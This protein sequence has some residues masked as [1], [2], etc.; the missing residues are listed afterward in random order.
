MGASGKLETW[1]RSGD[2]AKIA[3]PTLVIGAQHDTMDPKHMAWMAEQLPRG[4]F[5]LCPNGGHAALYDDQEA[6]FK[7]LLAFLADLDAGKV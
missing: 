2:L 5:L 6:Y 4:R 3:A 1:D 7:G